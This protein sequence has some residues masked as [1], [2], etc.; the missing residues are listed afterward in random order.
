MPDSQGMTGEKAQEVEGEKTRVPSEVAT[1][2]SRSPTNR[3][4]PSQRHHHVM[5]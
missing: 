5:L 4:L 2:E 3:P 1:D